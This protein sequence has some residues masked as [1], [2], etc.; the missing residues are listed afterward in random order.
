[1]SGKRLQ[2]RNRR[3]EQVEVATVTATDAKN[4]FGRVLDTAMERG[5]VAITR[6]DNAKAVLLSLDEFNA[7]VSGRERPLNLLRE[8]FDAMYARMQGPKARTAVDKVF[9]MSGEELGQ[10]ALRAAQKRRG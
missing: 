4:E 6:H 2:F 1:M 8:E 10:V 7:L 5:A 9:R 3:G